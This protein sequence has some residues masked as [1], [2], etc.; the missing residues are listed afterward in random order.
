MLE[1]PQADVAHIGLSRTSD[2]A[3]PLAEEGFTLA[4]ERE[5]E[6]LLAVANGY[7]GNRASLAEGSP[8]SAPATL[9]AGI[10]IQPPAPSVPEL[11]V[12]PDWSGV[13]IWIEGQPLS[14]QQGQ[15]LEHRRILDLRRGVLWREWRHRDANGRVTYLTFFR[16]ASMAD[17]HL[18][19]QWVAL[20]PE[21]Y[22]GMVT[23]EPRT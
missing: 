14:M 19:L 23:L 18:L 13:R 10:F 4:R 17:R 7:V 15:V 20:R 3:W 5:I 1:R 9:V 21:N 8:L 2:P 6:S 11:L 12:L 16:L 22:S